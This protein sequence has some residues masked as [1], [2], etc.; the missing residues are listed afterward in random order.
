MMPCLPGREEPDGGGGADGEGELR[1][2]QDVQ[3]AGLSRRILIPH[4][5]GGSG[6][7]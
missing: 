6:Q 5:A 2:Q 3:A 4:D 1:G 7:Q